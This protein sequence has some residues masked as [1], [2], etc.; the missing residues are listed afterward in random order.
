MSAG[1][2]RAEQPCTE[3]RVAERPRSHRNCRASL[4]GWELEGQGSQGGKFWARQEFL[5]TVPGSGNSSCSCRSKDMCAPQAAWLEGSWNLGA[6]WLH[7]LSVR[8][9]R[10]R[11]RETRNV[12]CFVLCES[13]RG[14]LMAVAGAFVSFIRSCLSIGIKRKV[15]I[16]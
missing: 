16:I 12:L 4:V 7:L 3:L 8:E 11:T 14:R 1:K 6:L 9:H 10:G 15:S 2:G 13:E 5:S